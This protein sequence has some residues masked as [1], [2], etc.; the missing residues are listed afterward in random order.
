MR[1]RP[2]TA[3]VTGHG[4][5]LEAEQSLLGDNLYALFYRCAITVVLLSTLHF[6][7]ISEIKKTECWPIYADAI[8]GRNS[9]PVNVSAGDMHPAAIS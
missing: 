8:I 6:L 1:A 7:C 5:S 2:A 3:R 4:G 9:D